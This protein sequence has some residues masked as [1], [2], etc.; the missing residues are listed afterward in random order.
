MSNSI[1]LHRP[2]HPLPPRVA[3]LPWVGSLPGLLR[4]RLEFLEAARRRYGDIYTL[5]FGVSR[6]I[7]LCHPRHAQHVLVDHARNYSKG[8]PMW[9]AI[10]TFVGNGLPVSEGAFWKRQRRMMQPA[11]HH[12]RLVSLVSTMVEEIDHNLDGWE[13]AARTGEPFN[14]AQALNRMTLNVLVRTLFGGGLEPSEVERIAQAITYIIDYIL[15]GMMTQRIPAWVPVPGR[16]RYRAAIRSLEESVL[17]FVHQHRQGHETGDNL[18]SLLID[19]VDAETDERMTEAQLR[20]EVMALFAAGYET[21][22]VGLS[23]MYHLLGEHPASAQRLQAEVDA[24]LG[25]NTPGFAE[26]RRLEYSRCVL[27]E[28]LRLYPPTYWLP[29]TAVE[30]DDID[31]YRIPAGSMV[32]VFTHTIH[33]HPDIWEEP[34]R[35]D[36]DRFSAERSKGRHR[37]AWLPFGAGQRQC[38]GKEFSLME[39]QLIAARIVQ[40]YQVTPVEGRKARLRIRT[41]LS[42]RE[43]VWVHLKK[44]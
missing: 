19:M 33:R 42:A 3:G 2:E 1:A 14:I 18:L 44:R 34:L 38:I 25:Q 37:L 29:R 5:D 13:R 9:D 28:A 17:R 32:G 31:G 26:L 7:V 27:Q 43:G 12:Q 8:G 30:D 23:W 15:Q 21:T 16:A 39:G 22:A 11:F 35:F 40:R 20:D 24:A 4:H 10:R 6:A 41:T 36:P